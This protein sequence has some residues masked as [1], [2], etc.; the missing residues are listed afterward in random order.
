[1]ARA[2]KVAHTDAGTSGQSQNV[3]ENMYVQY[4]GLPVDPI[5]LNLYIR[6]TDFVLKATVCLSRHHLHKYKIR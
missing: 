4:I 3:S 6:D 5:Y 2:G 1:M